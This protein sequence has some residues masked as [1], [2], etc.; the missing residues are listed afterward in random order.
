MCAENGEGI[1]IPSDGGEWDFELE[2]RAARER[3]RLQ[4]A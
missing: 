3:S 2:E 1:F 4:K